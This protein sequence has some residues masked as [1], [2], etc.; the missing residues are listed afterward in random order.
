MTQEAAIAAFQAADIDARVFFSP[1]SD[2]EFF[3]DAQTP[4]AHATARRAIN[5]PSYHDMTE[6]DIGRVCDVIGQLLNG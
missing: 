4:L 2:L 1:L 5:L 6:A 3:A